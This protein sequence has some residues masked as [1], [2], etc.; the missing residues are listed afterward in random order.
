MKTNVAILASGSGSN[1]ENII[2]YFGGSSLVKVSLV[3]SN[4]DNAYVLE[5][6]R[7]LNIPFAVVPNSDW[8]TGD[9]VMALLRQYQIDFIVLAGFL[10]RV[11]DGL[12]QAYPHRI[13]NI[14]PA[15]LPKFGGKGM[16]GDKVHQA[17]V[18]AGEKVSGIT[19]HYVNERYDEGQI[20]FQATCG[21]SPEDSP[22]AVAKKIHLLEQTYFPGIIE[23]TIQRLF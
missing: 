8:E 14:H 13:V 17:V 3:I 22:E 12:L 23:Q 21:V 10:L 9:E 2:R 11:P 19:I 6:A 15:L 5:R 18:A 20:I 16:Y 7:R 4:K 1:A